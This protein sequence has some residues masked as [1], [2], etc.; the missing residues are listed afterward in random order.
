MPSPG[1]RGSREPAVNAGRTA[2][3]QSFGPRAG[4]R[5]K[6]ADRSSNASTPSL[7]MPSPDFCGSRDPAANAMVA[8]LKSKALAR[9]RASDRSMR[10]DRPTH[11][12]HAYA[13][14]GFLWEPRPRGECDGR[15]AEKQSVGPRAGLLQ[16]HA[17]R[18]SNASTPSLPMPSPD[19]CASRDP[20]ANAMVAPLK[21]KASAQGRASYRSTRIDRP[22]HRRHALPMPSLDF[23][24]AATPQRMPVALQKAKRR[25]GAGLP[26]RRARD[27]SDRSA[28]DGCK[29]V[30][31][32]TAPGASTPLGSAA[33]P[34]G[35]LPIESSARVHFSASRSLRKLA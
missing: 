33:E 15:T 2:E 29:P 5:Q 9:G 31:R 10:I 24:G 7:P 21:S 25:P 32:K 11:R 34:V 20:A 8:P 23:V 4:L 18:S 28:F 16:K 26:Y 6:H 30:F 14:P 12:R 17:D 27:G 35:T 19:F 3:K 22:T 1:F 13:E